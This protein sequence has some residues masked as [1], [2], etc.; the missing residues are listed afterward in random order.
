MR[1]QVTPKAEQLLRAAQKTL[2]KGDRETAREVAVL[3]LAE[4]DAIQALDKLLPRVPEVEPI[5][6]LDLS[7]EQIARIMNCAKEAERRDQTRIAR[8]ILAKLERLEEK[9][10]KRKSTT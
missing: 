5:E 7:G 6:E 1:K 4:E 8:Q 9:K 2:L 3:A 10:K